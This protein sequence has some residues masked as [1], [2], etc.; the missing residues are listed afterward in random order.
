MS[1]RNGLRGLWDGGYLCGS[2]I[3]K[4]R[5]GFAAGEYKCGFEMRLISEIPFTTIHK[6]IILQYQ[7]QAVSKTA[8]YFSGW[9]VGINVGLSVG[10]V[11]GGPLCAACI[12][13]PNWLLLSPSP[14]AP[15]TLKRMVG[16][17]R[18]KMPIILMQPRMLEMRR[19]VLSSE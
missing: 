2:K 17:M 16:R 18:M 15:I 4:N 13:R 5:Y 6:S 1:L 8:W 14:R 9:L 3:R 7:Y 11:L 12:H 10:L 19:S